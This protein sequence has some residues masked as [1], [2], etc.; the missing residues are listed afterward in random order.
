VFSYDV[1]RRARALEVLDDVLA[2]SVA[3]R[4]SEALD[5]W[6]AMR[7]E[8]VRA[9]S[10]ARP[11]GVA[12]Y[13][14]ALWGEPEPF[15]KVLALDAAQFRQLELSPSMIELSLSHRDPAVRELGALVE[16]T[17]KRPG[18]S[19]RIEPLARDEDESVRSYARY[20]LATG[21]TGM[22]PEDD[23][24]TTLEKVLFL[25]RVSLFTE[26]APEDLMGLARSAEVERSPKGTVLF[27]QG[28]PGLALHL[29]IDGRVTTRTATGLAQTY[30][31]GEAF[32]ELGVLDG[33]VRSDDAEVTEDATILKIA[34][35]DFVEVL[36]ENGP[37][38]EAVIRVLV[39][40]LRALRS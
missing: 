30:G 7:A 28:D 36:R 17:M 11:D 25:Q 38:A 3:R 5:R 32:G 14:A 16:V 39:Q 4:F 9:P 10:G 29:V 37:L 23:M 13:V 26:V 1:Q 15:A 35:E 2:P 24:Y 27:R 34:R 8:L 20:V 12:H 6:I 22:S 31:E 18:W 40:R 33:T 19:A 21:R